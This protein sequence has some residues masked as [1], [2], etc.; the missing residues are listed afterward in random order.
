LTR[1]LDG[2][3]RYRVEEVLGSGGMALVYRARDEELDRPVAIKVLAD[4][5]AADDAF[6][7]RFLREARLAAQLA[8]PNVVRVFDSG[9]AGGRPYIV[10]EYVEG[11]T[12]AEL[13]ARRGRLSPAEAVELALQVC[14]GLEHAHHAGLVHRDVKPQ[15]L[16]IRGDGTIKIVDFGIA[17][18]AQGTQLTETGSVLGTAAYLAPEQAAGEE[19]TPATDVYAL[20]V[21]LY[22]MLAGRTPRTA[23]SLTQF[24]AA[25]HEQPIPAL[26]ELA[27]DVPERLE[28]VVMR[29]L[30]RLPEYRPPSAEALAAELAAT[31]A[32]LPTVAA[33]RAEARTRIAAPP[34]MPAG[35]PPTTTLRRL[36]GRPRTTALALAA[37]ALALLAVGVL[38]FSDDSDSTPPARPPAQAETS[39]AEQAREFSEWLRDN[40]QP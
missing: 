20:G 7:K 26:R 6:R 13:L 9:E 2:L 22:E 39:A 15:N 27:G 8:H 24:L 25:G 4:N 14:S 33:G 40:S 32:E 11:E 5:L 30:A 21:V 34:A 35:P 37:I 10:M 17:R 1:Q 16:I 36:A 19:V 23:E 31:A 38:A 29:C 28:N 12:L 3:D 18:S